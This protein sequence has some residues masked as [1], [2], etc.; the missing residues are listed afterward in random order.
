MNREHR[1]VYRINENTV[2]VFVLSAYGHY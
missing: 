1:I 2:T